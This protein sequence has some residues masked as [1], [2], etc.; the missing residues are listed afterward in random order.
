[1]ADFNA[2][3]NKPITKAHISFQPTALLVLEDGQVFEGIGFGAQTTSVGEVCFNTSMSGYQEIMTDPSYAGQI[4]NFTFPHI[5][6]IG[7]NDIDIETTIPSCL[8]MIVRNKV[9]SPSNWRATD[10]LETWLETHNLPGIAGIDTRAL[11]QHIR[12]N[13]APR[14]VICHNQAGEF[15]VKA[16]QEMAKNWPGLEGMD[17]AKEVTRDQAD[18]WSQGVYDLDAQAHKQGGGTFNVVALDYGIKHNILRC[19]Y[20]AGCSVTVMPANSTADEVMAQSPDGVFLSNGPGDPAATASYAGKEIAAI[21]DK[22]VPVFGICIGHQLLVLSQGGKTKKMERGHRGA[23][24]PVKD[25]MTGQ[26][27][28]TSQN[29]GFVV[30]EESLPTH[31]EVTHRSLFDGSVEGVRHKEKPMFCVQ[32]HPESS[33]GPHDSRHLFTRFTNLMADAKSAKQER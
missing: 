2:A 30:D 15:D 28:I 1:M 4:I 24:H 29:H 13:G 6:N 21:V 18:S 7:T 11:T 8:G 3:H 26:I 12:D 33:P 20:D 5:G 10:K 14:G 27:E 22:G 19:L 32:Y 9:T 17:L 16:L 25:L 31:L 23:N